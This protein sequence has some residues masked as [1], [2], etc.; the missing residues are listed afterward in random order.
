MF[1]GNLHRT[2]SE[3]WH[4]IND[5]LTKSRLRTDVRPMFYYLEKM[6]SLQLLSCRLC[7]HSNLSPHC[8]ICSAIF[9]QINLLP[10]ETSSE[11]ADYKP[12]ADRFSHRFATMLLM[13]H[14]DATATYLKCLSV[15]TKQGGW[16]LQ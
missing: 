5:G 12:M 3:P 1:I 9:F 7:L 10:L 4:E 6:N 2:D 16:P 8:E 11:S 14:H 15:S 13:C